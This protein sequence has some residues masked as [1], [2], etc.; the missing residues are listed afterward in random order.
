[1]EDSKIL[2]ERTE[3]KLKYNFF[4]KT[5][6]FS[7]PEKQQQYLHHKQD[8]KSTH[9]LICLEKYPLLHP[10][11]VKTIPE[12][13]PVPNRIHR[14]CRESFLAVISVSFHSIPYAPSRK[15]DRETAQQPLWIPD[16]F[17]F[18]EISNAK[19]IPT[20]KYEKQREVHRYT[21]GIASEL[22]RRI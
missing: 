22:P 9:I 21:L 17:I 6:N 10:F 18:P 16:G 12:V 4:C 11:P 13:G 15:I 5:L 20:A 7:S 1:M 2:F 8:S 14:G 3:K 19:P